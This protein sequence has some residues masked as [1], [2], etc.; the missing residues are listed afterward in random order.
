[1][2]ETSNFLKVKTTVIAQLDGLCSVCGVNGRVWSIKVTIHVTFITRALGFSLTGKM[3]AQARWATALV[4]DKIPPVLLEGFS[5][6]WLE[7]ELD[8]LWKSWLSVVV[9][10]Y[11]LE[12]NVLTALGRIVSNSIRRIRVRSFSF[13]QFA[14]FF[15][16][17]CICLGYTAN[18]KM[19]FFCLWLISGH[20]GSLLHPPTADLGSAT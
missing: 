14:S 6:K 2:T 7:C 17:V 12:W 5:W 3:A 20:D 9:D 8:W 19:P 18:K 16:E 4:L 10:I 13:V 11:C 1:M 15:S